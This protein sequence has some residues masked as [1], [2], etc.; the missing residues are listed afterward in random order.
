MR[1]LRSLLITIIGIALILGLA[2]CGGSSASANPM[3]PI[4]TVVEV[5]NGHSETILTDSRGFALYYYTPDSK[6]TT[7][8]TGSCAT[9]WPPLLSTSAINSAVTL[10]GTLTAQKT[11]NGNQVEYNG[12]LLYTYEQDTIAGQVNGDND[13]GWFVAT[14][15]LK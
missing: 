1:H 9:A 4:N 6:T 15:S 14:P 11:D 2:A 7:A 12:H 13:G 5:V 10:P 8:C 3:L